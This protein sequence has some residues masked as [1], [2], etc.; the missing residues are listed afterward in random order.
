MLESFRSLR[1]FFCELMLSYRIDQKI[2]PHHEA[3]EGHE[4]IYSFY[5]LELRTTMLENLHGLRKFSVVVIVSRR[6]HKTVRRHHEDHE[7]HGD[8]II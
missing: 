3:H 4:E 5:T 1:K 8:R 7:G 2:R 6:I